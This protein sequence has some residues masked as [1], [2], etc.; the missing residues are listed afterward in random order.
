M[1]SSSSSSAS[2]SGS[3]SG[4]KRSRHNDQLV[5]PVK[6]KQKSNVVDLTNDV[7][8]VAGVWECQFCTFSHTTPVNVMFLTCQL[9]GK[10]RG[11]HSSSP[12]PSTPP[13]DVG[14][15]NDS[16]EDSD[17]D[18]ERHHPGDL[19]VAEDGF[20]DWDENCHGKIDTNSNRSEYPDQF[21][22]D[23][24]GAAGDE[25]GCEKGAGE[26]IEDRYPPTPPPSSYVPV[27]DGDRYHPGELE[28]DWEDGF[29]DWDE[30]CHG[31]RDTASN[32]EE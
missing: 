24:C 3:S 23:C 20:P 5:E 16:D 6:K 21:E 18:G 29:A 12:P 14:N 2:S 32:R 10:D 9:C 27:Q 4:A 30:D 19:I 17:D 11:R 31:P 1:S 8:E 15:V 26:S 28:V 25:E 7:D 13:G 22:W